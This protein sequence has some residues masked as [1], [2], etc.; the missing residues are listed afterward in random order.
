[1]NA[2]ATYE[3]CRSRELITAFNK[4]TTCISY[5]PMTTERS[6]ISKF[7]VYESLS[8]DVS[9]SSYFETQNFNLAGMDNF[10]NANKNSLSEMKH[11]HDTVSTVFQVKPEIWRS[12]PTMI[13]IDISGIKNL[14]KLKC[15]EK[16]YFCFNQ[17]L[18]LERSLY[19]NLE[20]ANNS[21]TVEFI[22]GCCQSLS[23][24]EKENY[25]DMIPP[26]AGIR[27]L[28]SSAEIPEMHV[29]FLPFISKPV[30]EY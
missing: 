16:N 5:K 6:K 25:D 11:A 15:Q 22:L 7:E 9:L 13:S 30:S 8:M 14:D 2:H 19:T 18:S 1:M 17:K 12:K 29:G 23:L 21:S 28:I 26:W 10:D 3:R 20:I 24:D 4:Q 27:A